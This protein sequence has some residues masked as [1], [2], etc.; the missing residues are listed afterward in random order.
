MAKGVTLGQAL[1]KLSQ[2]ARDNL[3][4]EARVSYAGQSKEFRRASG[5]LYIT[6]VF[7]LV[8]VFLALAAQFESWIAPAVIMV[9][10]PLAL[11]GALGIL[12]LTNQTLNVYSQ[13]GMILLI[14][15]MAK[16]GILIVEFTNQLRGRGVEIHEAVLRA[17]EMRLRP[18]LMSSIATI[19]GAVPLSLSSGAGAEARAAIGWVIIGGA[20][21]STLVTLFLVPVLFRLVGKYSAPR[22]TIGEKIDALMAKFGPARD[23]GPS[24]HGHKFPEVAK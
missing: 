4:A 16:N 10:V 18:I 19:C 14:G 23:A 5:L 24:G 21:L 1:E 20:S 17:A 3:P 9:A 8:V 2:I 11:T 22:S 13:I 15:L 12:L 6:F 7:A